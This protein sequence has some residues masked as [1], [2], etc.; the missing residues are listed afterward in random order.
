[1]RALLSDRKL[2]RGVVFSLYQA[3]RLR[4]RTDSRATGRPPRRVVHVA[5]SY[6]GDRSCVGGGER[7]AMSL[8]GEVAKHVETVFVSFG[9]ERDSFREGDLRVEI[10]PALRLMNGLTWDPVSYSFLRELAGADVVHCY[11][12]KTIVTN[13]AILAAATLRKRVCVTD[14]AGVG[15]HFTEMFPLA[16]FVDVFLPI[17]AYSL[18]TLP[19]F[20]RAEIIYGGVD[21]RF[22]AEVGGGERER[23]ALFVG[24]LLPHKGIN[25]LIEAVD[26]DVP[27]EVIGRPYSPDYFELLRRLAEGKNVKLVTD[28]SDEDLLRAYRRS[29]VTVLP[30]VYSDVYGNT[31]TMPEL[32]GLVMLESMACGTPVVCT[33]VGGMPEFVEDGV[34][35]FV[36]PPN[37]PPAL[38][39]RINHLLDNPETALRM[40]REGRRTVLEKFTWAATAE[41]CLTAY[42]GAA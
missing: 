19:Q 42:R 3:A 18:K 11:Q 23:K 40:G 28:A 13:L 36:V 6:F 20:K 30:S 34:T 41:R 14:L 39:E 26:K 7:Y 38:R 32:L 5:P 2:V 9:R 15:Y 21:E 31:Q 17:S 33:A 8:A 25:Y 16:D 22:A 24:R 10:Y 35:G 1:M 37:D 29:L 12:Y 4:A 27:L